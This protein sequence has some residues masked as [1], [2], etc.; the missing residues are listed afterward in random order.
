MSLHRITL[1]GK[2]CPDCGRHGGL[3]LANVLVAKSG[4]FSLAG[5]QTKFNAINR[6]Q[7]A[8]SLCNTTRIG[9]LEG[10]ELSGDDGDGATTFLSGHFVE[11]REWRRDER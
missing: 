7:L 5:V 2:A 10:A 6:V 8:C 3:T 9:R 4:S 1:S 11:V